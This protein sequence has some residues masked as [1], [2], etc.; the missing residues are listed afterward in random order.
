MPID[1]AIGKENA[2]AGY[3]TA[4]A[5]ASLHT[6]DPAGTGAAEVTGGT[7]AYARIA[8]TWT[9]GATDGVRTGTLAAPFDVPAG[10]DVTHIGL[11]TAATG[12]DYLDKAPLSTSFA[13]QGTLEVTSLTYTQS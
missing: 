8:I 12:G 5:Y 3:S 6:A 11:W 13:S 4:A 10:T 9:A 1:S 7:P 2:A